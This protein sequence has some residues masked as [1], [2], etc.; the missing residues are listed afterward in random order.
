MQD[1]FKR[2][3][4]ALG[5]IRDAVVDLQ[6]G[7]GGGRYLSLVYKDGALFLFERKDGKSCLSERWLKVFGVESHLSASG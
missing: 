6:L 4:V 2:L 3:R 7:G 1:D 5:L